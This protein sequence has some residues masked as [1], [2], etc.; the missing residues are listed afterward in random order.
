MFHTGRHAC[1][2]DYTP[3]SRDYTTSSPVPQG[4]QLTT[5]PPGRCQGTSEVS[6]AHGQ[7]VVVAHDQQ[8]QV[9]RQEPAQPRVA[10]VAAPQHQVEEVQLQ[11]LRVDERQRS[12]SPRDQQSPERRRRRRHRR[13]Y[14]RVYGQQ[15]DRDV[16]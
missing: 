3:N 16:S 13:H 15:P 8:P 4:T 2:R 11:Q 9:G 1:R 14:R 7:T 12:L 5:R 10:V 6:V